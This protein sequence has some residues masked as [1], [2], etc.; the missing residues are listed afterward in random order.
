[1]A[2]AGGQHKLAKKKGHKT[3]PLILY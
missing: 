3:A 2:T 1:M